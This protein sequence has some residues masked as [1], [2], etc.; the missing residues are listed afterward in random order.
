MILTIIII[1]Y[2]LNVFLNRWLYFRL[3]K[4]DSDYYPNPPAVLACFLSLVGTFA[5]S[6]ILL[7][8]SKLDFFKLK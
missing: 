5:L 4:I 3:Q 2:I 7:S 6:V 8:N 1:A